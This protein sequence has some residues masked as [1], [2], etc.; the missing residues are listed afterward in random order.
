MLKSRRLRTREG[1]WDS[2]E[3]LIFASREDRS[4]ARQHGQL[5][6][7]GEHTKRKRILVDIPRG[8]RQGFVYTMQAQKA[9]LPKKR[10]NFCCKMQQKSPGCSAAVSDVLPPGRSEGLL[11]GAGPGGW[12][13][14][15][16]ATYP[17]KKPGR[18][19]LV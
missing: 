17:K 11:G 13:L 19:L 5:G 1:S 6:G 16:F 7:S 18:R 4:H 10:R 3:G 9:L 8:G 14:G 2:A 12:G 15:L